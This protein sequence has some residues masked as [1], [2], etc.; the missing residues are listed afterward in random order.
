M[1]FLTCLQLDSSPP[2]THTPQH[3]RKLCCLEQ[4]MPSTT[5]TST[6]TR[7]TGWGRGADRSMAVAIPTPWGSLLLPPAPS[8][9]GSNLRFPPALKI[10]L[11]TSPVPLV[12]SFRIEYFVRSLESS[13]LGLPPCPFSS[14]SRGKEVRKQ[15]SLVLS[16]VPSQS[17]KGMW[18]QGPGVLASVRPQHS[19]STQREVWGLG[20]GQGGA[21]APCT[22]ILRGQQFLLYAPP[23]QGHLGTG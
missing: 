23:V 19:H 16:E 5:L 13:R 4:T 14:K 10:V 8:V 17:H 7:C 12:T 15:A 11:P 18:R 22:G 1:P 3:H 21:G 20:G 9:S 2:P 6:N